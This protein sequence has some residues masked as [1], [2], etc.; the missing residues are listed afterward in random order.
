[1]LSWHARRSLNYV[2]GKTVQNN[3]PHQ[4][5]RTGADRRNS[6][7]WAGKAGHRRPLAGGPGGEGG[8]AQA[9]AGQVSRAGPAGDPRRGD[10]CG[11]D[12]QGRQSADVLCGLLSRG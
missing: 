3:L 10:V 7:A 6:D 11:F 1:M 5:R 9:R 12:G 4:H 8:G 2:A